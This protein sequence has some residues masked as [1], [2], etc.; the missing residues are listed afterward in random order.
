MRPAHGGHLEKWTFLTERNKILAA[1]G[2][3]ILSSTFIICL[4]GNG[5]AYLISAQGGKTH[6][7]PL[8]ILYEL[9][10]ILIDC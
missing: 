9:K 10:L 2:H 1:S 7:T 4:I 6:A 5:A 8:C 3:R